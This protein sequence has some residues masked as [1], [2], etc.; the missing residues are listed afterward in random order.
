VLAETGGDG[1]Q[2]DG[3]AANGLGDVESSGVGRPA[4]A[5]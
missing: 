2:H 1:G 4:R 5:N 3:E